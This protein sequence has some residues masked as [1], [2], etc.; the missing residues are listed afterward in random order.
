MACSSNMLRGFYFILLWSL[1]WVGLPQYASKRGLFKW[2]IYYIVEIFLIQGSGKIVLRTVYVSGCAHAKIEIERK[3]HGKPSRVDVVDPDKKVEDQR[4]DK[5]LDNIYNVM[6]VDRTVG[7]QDGGTLMVRYLKRTELS[8]SQPWEWNTVIISTG[9]GTQLM[10]TFPKKQCSRSWALR[11]SENRLMLP[12]TSTIIGPLWILLLRWHG[13]LDILNFCKDI[14]H[15][16]CYVDHI[17][18]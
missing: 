18:C 6:V 14:A 11:W 15:L 8:I 1:S 12:I 13:I 16:D 10:T 9:S 17:T 7:H 2:I 5:A 4:A 3:V